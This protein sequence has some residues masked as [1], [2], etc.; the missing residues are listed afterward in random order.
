[1]I[2]LEM[3]FIELL[4]ENHT[5]FWDVF[6]KFFTKLGDK[7][8]FWIIIGLLLFIFAKNKKTGACVLIALILG[9]IFG[10]L[11][12]KNL[13]AR[14][15]PFWENPA[16]QLIIK[17]PADYSFPSGHTIASFGSGTA[18]FKNKKKLGVIFIILAALIGFSRLYLSVHYPTDVVLG[19][20]MGIFIGN[21]SPVIY[22]KFIE[23][24]LEK[25]PRSL[26]RK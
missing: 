6:F 25:I 19:M 23:D 17:E 21:I 24:K 12:V 2:F 9:V 8:I 22:D 3:R 15:R 18:V 10:N 14:S 16:L 26:K 7:G 4:Y 11:I 20:A 13:A 1:M 5:H